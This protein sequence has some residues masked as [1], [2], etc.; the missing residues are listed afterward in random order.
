MGPK[1]VNYSYERDICLKSF[2]E[3]G[4]IQKIIYV[5]TLKLVWVR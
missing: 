3:L 2:K 4:P 5:L 1:N